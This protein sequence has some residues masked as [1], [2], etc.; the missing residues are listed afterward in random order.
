MLLPV[1][2]NEVHKSE[3]SSDADSI[4]AAEDEDLTNSH[5][6]HGKNMPLSITVLP[7]KQTYD[8]TTKC[9]AVSLLR[10]PKIHT[11]I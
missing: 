7:V 6:T 8:T 2:E 3:I 4:W 11:D 9:R 5:S 1:S 10:D